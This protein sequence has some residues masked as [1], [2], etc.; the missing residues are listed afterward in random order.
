MNIVEL[1]AAAPALVPPAI[2]PSL[3]MRWR[4]SLPNGVPATIAV[5]RNWSPPVKNTPV[6]RRTISTSS[7]SSPSPRRVTS[8]SITS[9]TPIFSNSFR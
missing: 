3:K 8:G 1:I 9:A 7:P 6:A 5:R 4:I 2:R